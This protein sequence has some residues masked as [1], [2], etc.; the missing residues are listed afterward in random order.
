MIEHVNF[1]R[2]ETECWLARKFYRYTQILH[3]AT[4]YRAV[5]LLL[6]ETADI[7]NAL[8]KQ[9]LLDMHKEPSESL[10]SNIYSLKESGFEIQAVQS[11][12]L[13]WALQYNISLAGQLS[14][15]ELF[16][17]LLYLIAIFQSRIL[18]KQISNSLAELAKVISELKESA[19]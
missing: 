17:L 14:L 13:I 11:L 7:F 6:Y 3:Y 19:S 16:V 18:N 8:S 9:V 12:I 4:R 10:Y 5:Q 1:S 15:E 2:S